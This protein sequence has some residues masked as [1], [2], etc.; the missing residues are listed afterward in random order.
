MKFQLT[1]AFEESTEQK[2]IDRAY[3]IAESEGWELVNLKKEAI[4]M[5]PVCTRIGGCL[6]NIG[7]PTCICDK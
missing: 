7:H 1:L 3:R 2:A 4:W 6:H 5:V